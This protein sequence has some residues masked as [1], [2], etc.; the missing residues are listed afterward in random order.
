MYRLLI[1]DDEALER[2]G[3]EW[4]VQRMLPDTFEIV[5]AENGRRAIELAE[6]RRPNI[7]L[8][9]VQMPGIQGLEALREIRKLLPDAKFVLVTAYDSFHYAQEALTLG[10]KEYIVKPASREQVA[11]LL[12]RLADELDQ[13]R[14][15]RA[16]HLTLRNKVSTLQPLVENELA[17]ILMVDQVAGEGPEQLAQWLEFPLEDCRCLVIAFPGHDSAEDRKPLYETIRRTAKS[18][19]PCLVSSIVERHL[20]V[21]LRKPPQAADDWKEEPIRLARKLNDVV[22]PLLKTEIS[23]GIGSLQSGAEGLRQS[24]FEA[25]FAST[26]SDQVCLFEDLKAGGGPRVPGQGADS[27]GWQSYVASALRRIREIREEQ[28]STVIDRAKQYIRQH[29]SEELSLEEAAESVHLNPFYFSKVFKQHVGETF[30]DYLTGLRIDRA[31]Q[32]IE[33]ED[34]SLKEVSYQVGYKDPNYFSRVFKKVTGVAPSE[35]RSQLK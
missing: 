16:E 29:Y 20:A 23:I 25:V 33:E 1:A 12:Q 9:D 10:V 15:K 19:G 4:I 2:E 8:M 21:F 30:I 11:S 32:L 27:E 3:L 13:E 31:K 18:F 14:S 6:E 17:L 24:Y 28:T 35:Y 7:V 22:Q 34:L 26:C 5:Q